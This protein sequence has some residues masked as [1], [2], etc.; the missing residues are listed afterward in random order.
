MKFEQLKNAMDS[1]FVDIQKNEVLNDYLMDSIEL[2]MNNTQSIYKEIYTKRV[3]PYKPSYNALVEIV[4]SAV[5][6][7]YDFK[8]RPTG[9]QIDKWFNEYGMSYKEFLSPL[10]DYVIQERLEME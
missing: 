7:D 3:R 8:D 10:V 4:S 2:V 9:K 6:E 1:R 5:Y